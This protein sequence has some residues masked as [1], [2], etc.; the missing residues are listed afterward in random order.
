MHP[1]AG[2]PDTA[3]R[4]LTEDSLN[5]SKSRAQSCTLVEAGGG[6][7]GRF[8]SGRGRGPSVTAEDRAHFL[9]D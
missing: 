5:A 8:Q 6:G 1:A 4:D 2:T 3:S 7:T 9:P